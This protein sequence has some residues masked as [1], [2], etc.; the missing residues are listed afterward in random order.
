MCETIVMYFCIFTIIDVHVVS[1]NFCNIFI[2]YLLCP[3]NSDPSH[4][5]NN[6]SLVCLYL[7]LYISFLLF[8]NFFC[9]CGKKNE[10]KCTINKKEIY[11]DKYIRIS[12]I[13]HT[14]VCYRY[15][16]DPII[17]IPIPQSGRSELT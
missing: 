17:L 14:Q 7:S 13:C 1:L 12:Y 6:L 3:F 8:G 10:K 2:N 9:L 11:N 16:T 4:R 5:P 15:V